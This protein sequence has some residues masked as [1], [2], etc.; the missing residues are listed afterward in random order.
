MP[1][2]APNPVE[3]LGRDDL[4][5]RLDDLVRAGGVRMITLTGPPGVGKSRVGAHFC[6]TLADTTGA[7]YRRCALAAVRDAAALDRAVEEVLQR[8][9]TGAALAGTTSG[10]V[11]F[12]DA[13]HVLTP[14]SGLCADLLDH[15]RDLL[16]VVTSRRRVGLRAEVVVPVGPL[17]DDA[18]R[19]LFIA[20]S[21]ASGGELPSD[22]SADDLGAIVAAA[23]RT[24]LAL[25]ALATRAGVFPL[26]V[27][28]AEASD[29]LGELEIGLRDAAPH[30]ASLDMA[31]HWSLR[32]LTDEERAV[33]RDLATIPGG[34]DLDAARAVSGLAPGVLEDVVHRLH[35]HSLVRTLPNARFKV[36]RAVASAIRG[37]DD[38][39]GARGRFVSHYSALGARL[40]AAGAG[41]T[42]A[43]ADHD[44]L[45]AAQRAICEPCDRR[46]E[47]ARVTHLGAP[48]W[49]GFW[50]IDCAAVDPGGPCTAREARTGATGCGPAGCD[51]GCQA[52]AA[53][54]HLVET[55]RM[56]CELATRSAGVDSGE[57]E[58]PAPPCH[59]QVGD[60]G[61]AGAP[62]LVVA[63]DGSCFRL[64]GDVVDL[65]ARPTLAEVLAELTRARLDAPGAVVPTPALHARVWSDAG[66]SRSGTARLYVA[67]SKLRRLGLEGYLLR[68]RGGY[69]LNPEV[70]VAWCERA[71]ASDDRGP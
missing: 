26:P 46:E 6:R 63:P 49:W 10:V 56:P 48:L 9:A 2:S 21:R 47:C 5:A 71:T 52:L 34:F 30:H 12:D 60:A 67:V 19:Q 59:P 42:G 50:G 31:I 44:N 65:S 29:R 24:P 17:D 70:S 54:D 25:E 1:H 13:D 14:L 62:A 51:P 38:E 40:A 15:H 55:L 32:L 18:A 69:C 37:G 4:V 20:R 68:G 16:V 58:E 45:L 23:D 27:L 22:G 39:V 41:A 11:L 8:R 36:P 33:L 43:L 61:L 64:H 53:V 57:P 3:L 28:V 7:P 35:G 66:E